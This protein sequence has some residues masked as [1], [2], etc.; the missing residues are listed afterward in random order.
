MSMF[1]KDFVQYSNS[2]TL[3]EL[4]LKN[5]G[6]RDVKSL[7]LLFLKFNMSPVC[8]FAHKCV[9]Q[10]LPH[11]NENTWSLKCRSDSSLQ[12]M[13]SIN[14]DSPHHVLYIIRMEKSVRAYHNASQSAQT[15]AVPSSI[16]PVV[17][18]DSE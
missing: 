15:T 8:F 12:M 13:S 18:S 3:E 5:Q 10:F 11:L 7:S 14:F 9:S 1:I 16:G 4:I 6:E 2:A 17:A